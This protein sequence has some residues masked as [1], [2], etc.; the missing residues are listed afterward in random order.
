M[1]KVIKTIMERRSLR[2]Y[3]TQ[4][5]EQEHID[6]ILE[7]AM[8]APTAGN[9]GRFFVGNGS[10]DTKTLMSH[11]EAI[12]LGKMYNMETGFIYKVN[13]HTTNL[14]KSYLDNID[15][16]W[17][18]LMEVLDPEIAVLKG[19]DLVGVLLVYEDKEACMYNVLSNKETHKKYKTNATYHQ[20]ASGV[21]GALASIL[22]DNITP[23]DILC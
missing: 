17:S 6:A 15:E 16:L 10:A 5:I 18:H 2:K 22:N 4:C 20:I 14:I 11:E 13:D 21:Y 3:K 12:T 7:A 1:N 23:R 8:R 9:I 19:E